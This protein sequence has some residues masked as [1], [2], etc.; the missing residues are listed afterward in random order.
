MLRKILITVTVLVIWNTSIMAEN[1]NIINI[2][3]DTL[4]IVNDI[5]VAMDVPFMF[6]SYNKSDISQLKIDVQRDPKFYTLSPEKVKVFVEKIEL[7]KQDE[8]LSIALNKEFYPVKRDVTVLIDKIVNIGTKLWDLVVANKPVLN[9]ETR[10]AVA[11]P[12]G[13]TK[14]S[15]LSNWSK[16]QSYRISFYF[17]NLY[18]TDVISVSYIVTYIYNGNYKGKGKYIAGVWAIP[19]DVSVMWGFEFDM[20]AEVPDLTIVNVGTEE[21]PVAAL[22]LKV[23]W[24]ARSILKEIDGTDVFYIQGDGYFKE[25]SAKSIRR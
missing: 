20:S 18:G 1:K 25:L 2:S 11:L 10:Y 17:K 22:Q 19:E 3:P 5:P 15:E 13:V 8:M 6:R 14:P 16:P 4:D 24:S 23:S 9:V 21:N 7:K 12:M